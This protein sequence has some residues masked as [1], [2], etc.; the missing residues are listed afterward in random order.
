MLSACSG[1][2]EVVPF[3]D[4]PIATPTGSSPVTFSL[5]SIPADAPYRIVASTIHLDA[6]VVAMGWST[7]SDMWGTTLTE[8][9]MPYNEAGWHINS[10]TPG[11]GSNIVISGHNNSLGGRVFGN[12]EDLKI[13]DEITLFTA[14]NKTSIYRVSERNIVRAVMASEEADAYLRSVMLPTDNEQLTLITC[15]PSWSNTHRLIVIA[16]P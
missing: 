16:K 11:T 8:W 13:G 10:A 12:V 15:W 2:V 1:I 7:A 6:S 14:Q 4:L 5:D 9:D 3:S